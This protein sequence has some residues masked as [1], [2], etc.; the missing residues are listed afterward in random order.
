MQ[1]YQ[2]FGLVFWGRGSP[3]CDCWEGQFFWSLVE[4]GAWCKQV[5]QRAL[6]L[7][8]FQSGSV[9]MLRGREGNGIGSFL[10]SWRRSLH[11]HYLSEICSE[12]SNQ[13]PHCVSQA[14]IRSLFL[15]CVSAGCLPCIFSKSSPSVLWA[16]PEPNM[17]TLKTPGFKLH[18]L[19]ELMKFRCS[20]FPSQLLWGFF[21]SGWAP[22]CVSLSLALLPPTFFHVASF[23]PLIVEFFLPVFRLISGVFRMIW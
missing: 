22:L 15:C 7:H 4:G 3:H 11:E 17:L 2:N 16:L 6:V 20:H 5:K 12:M 14:L 13:P 8:W 21:F 23:L 1:C 9:F 10:C 19:Q 18:C